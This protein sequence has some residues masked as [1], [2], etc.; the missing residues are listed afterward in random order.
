MRHLLTPAGEAALATLASRPALLAFDFDGTLAPIVPRPELVEV[1]IGISE[2]LRK[3]SHRVALAV[4]TGRSLADVRPRLGFEPH[5]LVG[6]HG[7]EGALGLHTLTPDWAAAVHERLHRHAPSLAAAGV[8]VEDKGYSLA[9]HYR[10][11]P[12]AEQ[13]L[14][15]IET[16]LSGLEASHR[17]FGGKCVL[18]VA[19]AGAPD[20]G[21][22]LLQLVREAK[23]AS[24]MFVG[25]DVNDEPAF[26]RAEAGWVT[27]RIGREMPHSKARFYLESTVEM[28]ATLERLLALLPAPP[29]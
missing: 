16:A 25:D 9:L 26:A 11:A 13:A 27:V 29:G 14:R 10:L 22:A 20:K 21:D 8:S 23:V 18:N 19:P 3:L 15:V 6:N 7:A 1:P 5:Y 12:D 2:R 28:E 4:I 17:I 24:A